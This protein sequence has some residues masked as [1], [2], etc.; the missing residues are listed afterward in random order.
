MWAHLQT[1]ENNPLRRPDAPTIIRSW[2]WKMVTIAGIDVYLHGTFFLLIVFIALSDLGNGQGVAAM[3]RSVVLTIAIFTAVVLHEFG[4]AL[5]ARHFGVQTR[6]ITLWPIGGIA[7]LEKMPEKPAQQLLVA[8]AGPGVNLVIALLLFGAIRLLNVPVGFEYHRYLGES[9][10][11]QLMWFNLSLALFNL[12]PGYPMDGGR[13]LRALL[14]MRMAP[15]RATQIA[16]RVGQ[17]VAVVLGIVGII[18]N[19]L[20]V[21]IA[22][23]VWLGATAEHA[24]STDS[25]R[26]GRN[27]GG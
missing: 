6:N 10:V 1:L 16:A 3:L 13:V 7:S 5:T 9:F 24:A 25:M 26:E 19:S 22:L 18:G 17:G 2:S 4:H 12:L 23:F 15:M 27:A 21:V 8:L 14:A 20:L 11:T